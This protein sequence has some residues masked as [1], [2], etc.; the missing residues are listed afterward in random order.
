KLTDF[1]LR[2]H[3]VPAADHALLYDT[4]EERERELTTAVGNGAAIPHGRVQHGSGIRGVLGIC[5][6][7]VDFDAYDGEPVRI[8][9]LVVTPEGYDKEHLE[10]MA[11]LA[12]MISD[13]QLRT[14][15]VAAINANDAWEVIEGEEA[16][17]YNYFLEEGGL[18]RG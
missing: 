15:L 18:E 2:T 11:S 6:E 9:M 12:Q 1:Y 14:R 5:R 4:I 3:R 13:E 8:L 17:N 10:V 7:G 16:R